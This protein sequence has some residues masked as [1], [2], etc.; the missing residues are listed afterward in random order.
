MPPAHTLAHNNTGARGREQHA[1]ETITVGWCVGGWES[2]S[3]CVIV[4]V[5]L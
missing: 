5:S 1:C 2:A 3:Q 4:C